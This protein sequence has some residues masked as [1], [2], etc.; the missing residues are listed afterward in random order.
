MAVARAVQ[1]GLVAVELQQLGA[2]LIQHS[3]DLGLTGIHEQCDNVNER[4]HHAPQLRGAFR[5]QA[6]P[7][8]G[9]KDKTNCIHAGRNGGVDI[10]FAGQSADL[11]ACTHG[12]LH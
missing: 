4:R 10:L 7:A 9:I 1:R 5:C 8:L 11:D 6:A 2:H 3:L 12:T